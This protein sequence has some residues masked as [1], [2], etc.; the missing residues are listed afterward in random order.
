MWFFLPTQGFQSPPCAI[1]H[2][3]KQWACDCRIER[4]AITSYKLRLRSEKLL[5][6]CTLSSKSSSRYEIQ[7]HPLALPRVCHVRV[8]GT[9]QFVPINR[10]RSKP[11]TYH[12]PLPW[13]C[14]RLKCFF[15][16][17]TL[18]FGY[19]APRCCQSPFFFIL[20]FG[21]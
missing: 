18:I 20:V 7:Y 2:H 17:H 1:G 14:T 9:Q 13:P 10:A 4:L 19:Q 5:P 16:H 8:L 3:I 12:S 11:S 15:F 6:S 21:S